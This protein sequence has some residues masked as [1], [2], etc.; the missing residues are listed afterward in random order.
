VNTIIRLHTKVATTRGGRMKVRNGF[1]CGHPQ[2]P[3]FALKSGFSGVTKFG[4][5]AVPVAGILLGLKRD[6]SAPA[7]NGPE[8]PW[9]TDWLVSGLA[10]G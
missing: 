9:L 4:P 5:L 10:V 3:E 6:Q 1:P 8:S 2:K 7:T